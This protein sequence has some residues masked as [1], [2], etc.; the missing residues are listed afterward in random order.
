MPG[1]DQP[2]VAP[3]MLDDR[4]AWYQEDMAAPSNGLDVVHQPMHPSQNPYPEMVLTDAFAAQQH[5]P[6][7]FHAG[8]VTPFWPQSPVRHHCRATLSPQTL[9]LPS[10]AN[11]TG[12]TCRPNINAMTISITMEPS[13]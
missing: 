1:Q 9:P 6:M 4:L 11:T 3:F 12:S 2:H 7:P 13:P 8:E 5:Q 10:A